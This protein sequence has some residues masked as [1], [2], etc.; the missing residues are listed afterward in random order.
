MS[1]WMQAL[2]DLI[3]LT[4]LGLSALLPPVLCMWLCSWLVNSKGAPGW[5]YAIFLL[6]GLASGAQ[7]FRR[8]F[9][10]W[11]RQAAKNK[12]ENSRFVNFN[13]HR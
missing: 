5:L 13:E 4:Q 8:F 2:S 3:W 10:R 7:N 1:D 9:A 12:N 6:L 11:R